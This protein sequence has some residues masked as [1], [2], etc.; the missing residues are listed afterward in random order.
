MPPT[1][2][3]PSAKPTSGRYLS[4]S[5]RED[6]AI[7]LARGSGIHAIARKLG[8]SPSTISREVRR[9]AS[10]RGG[11]LHYRAS[12]AQWHADR[13]AQRPKASK[14]AINTRLRD[15]VAERLS[16]EINN[17][18]GARFSSPDVVWK[19]RRAVLPPEPAL[20][21]C[22]EPGADRAPAPA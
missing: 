11:T 8:R 12:T 1:H 18:E 19:G 9:N 17:P 21:V 20:V 7:E 3:A 2:L 5:E 10:N 4:F 13:A 14:L 15:Y 16:G 6:I 22:V